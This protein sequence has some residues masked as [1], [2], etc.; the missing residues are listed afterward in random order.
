[1]D[2]FIGGYIYCLFVCMICMKQNNTYSKKRARKCLSLRLL[3][4]SIQYGWLAQF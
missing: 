3:S 2:V 1:M 4:M